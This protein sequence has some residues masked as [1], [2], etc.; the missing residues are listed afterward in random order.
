MNSLIET[1][2]QSGENFLSFAWP[3][4]W[5]SSLLIAAVFAFDFLLR[6]RLR[7]SIRY[8]L[9]LVVLVKLC[10]PPTLALPTSPAWWFHQTPLTVVAKPLPHFTVTYDT[11]PLPEMPPAT[12]PVFVAPQPVMTSAA[13][14]LVISAAVS[15]ALFG[16][17]LVRWWQV[18]RLVRRAAMAE[19]FSGLLDEA[20][21]LAG[22]RQSSVAN[23]AKQSA[24]G[25]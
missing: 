24:A 20:M 17:L 9:W 7:A 14:L 19:Q 25:L 4:L 18:A 22:M 2:N 21:R 8:A 13:W 12:L 10:V 6:R 23:A 11:S 5:Q 15:F 16:W 3:M 1:L